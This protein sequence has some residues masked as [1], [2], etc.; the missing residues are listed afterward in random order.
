MTQTQASCASPVLSDEDCEDLRRNLLAERHRL[1]EEYQHEVE[2]A[3]AIEIEGGEDL[4]D[5]ASIEVDRDRLLAHSEQDRETLRLIEEALQRMEV[6][7]Y[8][9]CLR[10]GEPIPLE[11]L[12]Q[13]PWARYRTGVQER[14][15][16]GDLVETP[17]R[18]RAR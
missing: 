3:Q 9:L 12:R 11:R 10:T 14:I 16:S 15:E 17:R 1:V 7:T 13:I 8:G 4:E 5:L 18:P 6:G 2:A